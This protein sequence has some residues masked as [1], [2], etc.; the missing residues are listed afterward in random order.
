MIH[1]RPRR[2]LESEDAGRRVQCRASTQRFRSGLRAGLAIL[3]AHSKSKENS[4]HASHA[5][6]NGLPFGV[7]APGFRM[8]WLIY[9]A[10]RRSNGHRGYACN[11][12]HERSS[13]CN[14]YCNLQRGDDVVLDHCFDVPIDGGRG[15]GGF[16]NCQLLEFRSNLYA[17]GEPG[18]QHTVHGDH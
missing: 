14:H 11:R 6:R 16:R 5:S 9:A 18:L 4:Y 10:A 1:R 12:G 7:R 13:Q 15:R 2:L 3:S 17:I 8:R